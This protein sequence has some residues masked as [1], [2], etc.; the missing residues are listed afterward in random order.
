MTSTIIDSV[1]LIDIFVDDANWAD[2]SN[3]F[4]LKASTQ[5]ALIINPIIYA[6]VAA[7]FDREEEL[8]TAL[9]KSRFQRED[10]PYP[11]VFLA[12]QAHYQYRRSGGQRERTLP[13]FF[14]G[15]HALI[16]GYRLLTRDARRYRMHFP[17]LDIVAPDTHP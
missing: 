17:A 15:A 1:V 7:S 13:D 14:I 6:E 8:E 3:A 10:L 12:G 9:P 2:W 5:G 16:K 11:A 4:I